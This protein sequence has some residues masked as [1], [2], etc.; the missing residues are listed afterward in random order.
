[1]T[2][3]EIVERVQV[4]FADADAE[5]I[6][7][8]LAVQFNI[9]GEGHG[10][11]YLEVK[12]HQVS[13]EP[14]EYFNR[15]AAIRLSADTLFR[16]LNK[17]TTYEKE[18][19]EFRIAVEGSIGDVLILKDIR[20]VSDRKTSAEEKDPGISREDSIDIKERFAEELVNVIIENKKNNSFQTWENDSEQ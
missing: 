19:N 13:V 7:G 8:H 15:D 14:Y 11:F 9:T 12:D 10:A 20:T 16:I 3:H 18:L 5:M 17:E 6:K 1:M 2:F 4:H